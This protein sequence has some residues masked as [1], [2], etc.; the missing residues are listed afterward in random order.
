[1]TVKTEEKVRSAVARVGEEIAEL[2]WTVGR[3][4]KTEQRKR[5]AWGALQ[6]ALAA[7]AAMAARRAGA[8][9]W[10]VLTGERPPAKM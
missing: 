7:A 9:V 1:V 4:K 8:R 6:G 3:D 10:G 5:W 2:A